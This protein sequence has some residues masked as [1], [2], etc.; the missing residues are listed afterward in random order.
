MEVM[1]WTVNEALRT[2][3]RLAPVFNRLGID[4][5]CGGTM[6]LR[7]AAFS[8]GVTP[9]ELCAAVQPALEARR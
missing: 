2:A 5:C 8:V 3:P 4:T 9:D 6:T 7:Q 1:E